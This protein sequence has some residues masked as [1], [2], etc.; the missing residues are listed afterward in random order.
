MQMPNSSKIKFEVEGRK[1]V[2]VLRD[3]DFTLI[4]SGIRVVFSGYRIIIQYEYCYR[5]Y[6][7]VLSLWYTIFYSFVMYYWTSPYMDRAVV[8]TI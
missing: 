7:L 3:V 1:M 8:R 4:S 2:M 5:R 6:L